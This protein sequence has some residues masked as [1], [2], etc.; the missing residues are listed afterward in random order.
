MAHRQLFKI[1][2][3]KAGTRLPVHPADARDAAQQKRYPTAAATSVPTAKAGM[4]VAAPASG[5][6]AGPSAAMA[7]PIMD[8]ATTAAAARILSLRGAAISAS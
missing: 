2:T 8:E 4:V 6:G 7:T 1:V 3:N 5:L